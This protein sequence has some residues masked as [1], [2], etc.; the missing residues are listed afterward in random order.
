MKKKAISA[1][2]RK[3]S[4]SFPEWLKYEVTVFNEDGTTEKIPAYGKDLQDALSRVVH[5]EKVK[6]IGEKA[7]RIP[8]IVW[9]ALW[10]AYVLGLINLTYIFSDDNRFNGLFFI[11]GLVVMSATVIRA[12]YWL[13]ERNKDKK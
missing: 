2:Y 12:K 3:D 9:I 4:E 5:D 7:R 6:K 11:G 10:F 13:R 1:E 8:D